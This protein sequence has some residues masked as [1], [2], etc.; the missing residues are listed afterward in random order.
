M[1]I[2]HNAGDTDVEIHI[3]ELLE[4]YKSRVGGNY[5]YL[6]VMVRVEAERIRRKQSYETTFRRLYDNSTLFCADQR[7][8][9]NMCLEMLEIAGLSKK[10]QAKFRQHCRDIHEYEFEGNR[11]VDAQFSHLSID[12]IEDV[13]A[14]EDWDKPVTVPFVDRMQKQGQKD[15]RLGILLEVQKKR[16]DFVAHFSFNVNN[17]N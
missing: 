3:D 16:P 15:L 5:D 13:A 10:G 4:L 9:A 17:N 1:K 11:V 12:E 14:A 8:S 2:E 6:C 7:T